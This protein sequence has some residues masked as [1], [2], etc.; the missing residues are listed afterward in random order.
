MRMEEWR[1][2][3]LTLRSFADVSAFA[4]QSRVHSF[5]TLSYIHQQLYCRQMAKTFYLI[6]KH[7]D[8]FVTRFKAGHSLLDIADW[9]DLS[10]TMV[11]RRV[12]ELHSRLS[13][14]QVTKALKDL[15]GIKDERLREEIGLCV[16]SDAYS[17]P[18]V[19][20]IRTVIGVEYELRLLDE[21]RNLRVEFESEQELRDRGCHKTPDVLLR[22]PIGVRGKP[23][24]WID[25]KAKFGDEFTMTKDYTGSLSSYV[26]RFGPGMVIYWFGIIEDCPSPLMQDSG[27]LIVDKFPTDVQSL[28]G[29]YIPAPPLDEQVEI[30]PVAKS[31]R[32]NDESHT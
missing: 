5:E 26:G 1:R 13:R 10:P 21:L 27:V 24:C 19:D 29:T 30:S 16:E 18:H 32:C 28:P 4:R 15:S 2:L 12:L 7:G 9:I 14:Q 17:G 6:Q 11:A 25:S 20:R 3:K 31:I 23:I 22:V 8:A